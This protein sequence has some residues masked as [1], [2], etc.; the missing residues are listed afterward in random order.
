MIYFLNGSKEQMMKNKKGVTLIL[1]VV[2]IL[3]LLILAGVGMTAGIGNLDFV[4]D[5]H[6]ETELGIVRQVVTEQYGKAV[7][8]GKTQVNASDANVA[9]WL[10]ERITDF[11]NIQLPD[12]NTVMKTAQT[13][14]FYGMA[15]RYEPVYQED[16]YYRL[17]PEDLSKMGIGHA[18]ATYVVNYSTGEIYNETQKVNG[19]SNLLYLPGTSQTKEPEQEDHTFDDWNK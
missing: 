3:L 4:T 13:E 8:V 18:K 7:A 15:S 16:F 1:L 10:G 2:T 5:N 12:E 6:L 17:T 9:F 11:S 19:K 14:A